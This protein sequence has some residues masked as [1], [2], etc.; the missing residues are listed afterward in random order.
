MTKTQLACAAALHMACAGASAQVY[1]CRAPNGHTTYSDAPCAT[2][3]AGQKVE[4]HYTLD[5]I[6]RERQVAAG[7]EARKQ[8]R[9]RAEMLEQWEAQQRAMAAQAAAPQ[10]SGSD[11]Q[12]R[13]DAANAA[14]SAGSITKNGGGWDR[15][16]AAA[17]V[18]QRRAQVEEPA[19]ATEPPPPNRSIRYC[20][21]LICDDSDGNRYTRGSHGSYSSSDGRNCTVVA[22]SMRC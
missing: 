12:R 13:K 3:T 1:K 20:N 11:W 6:Q 10:P 7:A 22:G 14:T 4:R 9:E 2:G 8:A 15:E 17:R 16:A 5:E 21:D 18:R 19:P